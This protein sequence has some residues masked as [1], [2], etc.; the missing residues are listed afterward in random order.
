MIRPFICGL[1]A[2]DI[3]VH[4]H[5]AV[6]YLFTIKTVVKTNVKAGKSYH[7]VKNNNKSKLSIEKVLKTH[8]FIFP[9]HFS[10]HTN[11]LDKYTVSLVSRSFGILY[12]VNKS[13]VTIIK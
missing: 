2:A 4:L 10:L 5:P 6:L 9:L 13:I 8:L 12:I 3:T 1:S 7:T 11:L